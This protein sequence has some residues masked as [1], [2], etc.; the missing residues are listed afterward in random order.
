[1]QRVVSLCEADLRA[2]AMVSVDEHSVRVRAL[3]LVR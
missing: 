1:V 3:S 2:G